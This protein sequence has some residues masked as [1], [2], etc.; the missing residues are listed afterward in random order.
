MILYHYTSNEAFL[1][2]IE[3]RSI[4][5][6]NLQLSNDASEGRYFIDQTKKFILEQQKDF[7]LYQK[8]LTFLREHCTALGISFSEFGD[9]LSQWRAYADDGTGVSIGFDRKQLAVLV[10]KGEQSLKGMQLSKVKYADYTQEEFPSGKIISLIEEIEDERNSILQAV[11]GEGFGSK[12]RALH[13]NKDL[14]N[15][16]FDKLAELTVDQFFLKQPFFSEEQEWRLIICT[17]QSSQ[18]SQLPNLQFKSQKDKIV[19]YL[20][21]PKKAL[22][23]QIIK[24]VV[25]GPKNKTPIEVVKIFLKEKGF[26]DVKVKRSKGSY[27]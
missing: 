10:T 22:P 18:I 12:V 11:D 13:F 16:T 24:E 21:F 2:I 26:E 14:K 15:L 25:L 19:P 1:S 4:W 9:L 23:S 6:S 7:T 27:R 5:L 8:P 17:P 3:N 20:P